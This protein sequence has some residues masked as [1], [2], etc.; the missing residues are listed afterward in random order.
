MKQ[1]K[2]KE[3]ESIITNTLINYKDQQGLGPGHLDYRT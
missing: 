1:Q 2:Q 3:N